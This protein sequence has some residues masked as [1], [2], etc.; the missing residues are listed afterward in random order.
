MIS[1]R[2]SDLHEWQKRNFG[3]PSIAHVTLG[4]AEE[5]GEVCH[6]I[7][8]GEQG[9]RGGKNGID[10]NRVADG[11]AD[12]LIYGIQL[13]TLLGIDAEAV[14]AETIEKV[15]ARDWTKDKGGNGEQIQQGGA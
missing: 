14:I 8:K 5:S 15:L 10:V 6:H 4:I 12:T 1:L 13:L 11:V 3:T 2:Q 9:I 7:L